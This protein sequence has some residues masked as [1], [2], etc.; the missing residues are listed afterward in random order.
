M[1]VGVVDI[2]SNTIR[3][4]VADVEAGTVVPLE[5]E[6]VRLALGEEIESRGHLSETGLAAAAKSVRDLCA[7]A[8]NSGVESLDVFVTAPGRQSANA[9]ELV[10]ALRRAAEHPVRVLSTEEEGRLAY[11]GAVVTAEVPLPQRFAVC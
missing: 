3:L 5:N 10:A 11:A 2:G 6:R 8:R 9:D 4:L 1:R 7:A